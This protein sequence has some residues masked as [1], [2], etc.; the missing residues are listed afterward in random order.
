MAKKKTQTI[1]RKSKSTV[2]YVN[3]KGEHASLNVE[4][5]TSVKA[6]L[7]K[8]KRTICKV[9][10]TVTIESVDGVPLIELFPNASDYI[11]ACTL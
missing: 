5:M 2:R 7:R 1:K 9:E 3:H 10:T 8:A 11:E 6:T 4:T